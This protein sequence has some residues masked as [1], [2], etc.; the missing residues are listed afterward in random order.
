MKLTLRSLGLIG[1]ILFGMLFSITYKV[2]GFVE[3]FAKDFI[4]S[5][6]KKQTNEK[7]E[8]VKLGTKDSKL[9][10]L[11]ATL[12]KKNQ[13][14]IDEV[15]D[16]LKNKAYEKMAVVVAEM[17]DLS[18]E[19]R[20]KYSVKLKQGF[21][22]KLGS[23]QYM[24]EKLT[25]FMKG[26]YMEVSTELKR[27]VRIF[28]G[29]NAIIFLLLLMISFLKPQAIKHLYLPAMVLVV[30]TVFCAAFYIF[31][32]DWILTIIYN[33]YYGFAYLSYIGLVFLVFSDIVLNEGKVTTK[34]TNWIPGGREDLGI[35]C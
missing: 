29:S 16:Q 20:E 28:T 9:A 15:K 2:P 4:I 31:K 3:E 8:L 11:A 12:Y 22:F 1:T 10:M 33:D 25:D 27:D 19:C 14:K 26:K 13:K 32:Q 5:E 18:C 35:I 7:I 21:E 23:L 34:V 6:I 24:N 30:S 17:S